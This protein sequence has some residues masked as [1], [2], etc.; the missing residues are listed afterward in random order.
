MAS[1][2]FCDRPAIARRL[3][4]THYQERWKKGTIGQFSSPREE[5]SIDDRLKSK[6]TITPGPMSTPC[7]EFDGARNEEGY[8]MIWHKG[9]HIR[10]HRASYTIHK[11]EVPDRTAVLHHCDK[12]PCVNPDHLFLGNRSDNN[13]DCASKNRFPLNGRHHATK[14]SSGDVQCIRDSDLTQAE[15][16]DHY[17]VAQSTIS[18]IQ[19]GERRTKIHL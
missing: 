5:V 6:I 3:C 7:W 14:L 11:G 19:R 10:A 1:C 12:R 2:S 8:G 9:K 4:N 15:L 13:K 18:R 17:G 16:A